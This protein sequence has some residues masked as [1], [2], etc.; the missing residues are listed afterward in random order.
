MQVEDNRN[1]V[2]DNIQLDRLLFYQKK[3]NTFILIYNKFI[4]RKTNFDNRVDIYVN[5]F[6]TYKHWPV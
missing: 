3:K 1:E 4:L 2:Y 5:I 6:P